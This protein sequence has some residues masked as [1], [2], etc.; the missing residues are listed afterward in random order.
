MWSTVRPSAHEHHEYY[1][2]YISKVPDGDVLQTLRAGIDE[3]TAH[4]LTRPAAFADVRY[5]PGKWSIREFLAHLIDTERTFG[6]RAFWFA[7]AGAGEL[8]SLEQDDFVAESGASDRS[9]ES[10]L[11]EWRAVR[12][13]NLALFDSLRDEAAAR[14]G[15]ASGRAF[16]ARAC[17]W[18]IAGHEIHHRAQIQGMKSA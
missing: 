14:S 7:R 4:L 12:A 8:P 17:A 3:T 15:I 2:T 9:L 13:A 11:A 5:A 1:G 10:L 16:T 18:I 6:F